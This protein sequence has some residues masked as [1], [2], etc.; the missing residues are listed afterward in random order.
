MAGFGLSSGCLRR[1]LTRDY[2]GVGGPSLRA[3]L[4]NHLGHG[5]PL[6]GNRLEGIW[7]ACPRDEGYD[8]RDLLPVNVCD[9]VRCH[10]AQRFTILRRA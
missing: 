3:V 5:L 4:D 6:S 9:T 10:L 7:V 2:A 1:R 8:P